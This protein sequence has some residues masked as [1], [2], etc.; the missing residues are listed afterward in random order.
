M[1]ITL[2]KI[3]Y[4][5]PSMNRL[6][7]LL[8]KVGI[9]EIFQWHHRESNP[10][11]YRYLC[12]KYIRTIRTN[13]PKHTKTTFCSQVTFRCGS[14]VQKKAVRIFIVFWFYL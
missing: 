14:S 12:L 3:N 13:F 10:Y 2:E 8:T 11:T 9:N 4:L 6:A 7:L 1:D 5:K